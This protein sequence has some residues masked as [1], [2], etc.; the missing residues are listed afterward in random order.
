M[1]SEPTLIA[2]GG[3]GGLALALALA[4]D[5]RP[6]IVLERQAKFAAAGAGIQIGPNGVRALRRLGVAD[7][8]EQFAGV[9]DAIVVHDGA[10]ARQ[11]ARLPL[12]DWIAARHGSPYWVA[13]RADLHGV[14][15]DAAKASPHVTIR[16]GFEVGR[17]SETNGGVSAHATGGSTATGSA[18]IGADGLWSTVR[19]S[20][21][22]HVAPEFAGATATRA[23]IPARLAE[24]LAGAF[25]GL[26]LGP[27]AHVVHYPVRGGSETAVVVIA[28]E[29]WQGREWDVAADAADV[30]KRLAGFHS[31]L[32][33]VLGTVASWRKWAL[34]TLPELPAWTQ[35][36]IALLGD[37]A[38]PMLPFLAQGGAF[39]IEDAIVL[40][41]CLRADGSV[42]DALNRYASLRRKRARRAQIASIRQGSLY[43]LSPPL[44]YA[45]DAVLR[46]V[47]GGRL[48]ARLDWLYG[49]QPD[50]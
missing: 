23:V 13:H 50:A 27:G 22:P 36:R 38:H 47:P 5:A 24:R 32:I 46:L 2:G 35:G 28:R 26:W 19:R 10:S 48:M 1:A 33:T 25:V 4:K 8:L 43:R 6:S 44:S 21:S 29:P 3:I 17:V 20:L 49:W 42:P 30:L 15:L 31:S 45:R 16:T 12:G 37:A 41:D 34:Y 14:L 40:A 11:M 9:P 39:A 7:A 18:L